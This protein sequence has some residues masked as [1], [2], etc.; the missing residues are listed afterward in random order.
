M[1][2]TYRGS[3]H[4]DGEGTC[5]TT[6]ECLLHPNRNPHLG[7]EDIEQ[8]LR[9]YLNVDK[10][11]WLSKGL[12]ADED[13]NG[14]IDNFCAFVAPGKVVLACCDDEQDPQFAISKAALEILS[15]QVDAK[16]RRIEVIKM[17]CPTPM[18][19]TE[20]EIASYG[21]AGTTRVAGD[22][23]AGSYVNFYIANGE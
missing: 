17:P 9:D 8:Q 22:R 13:T 4:V 18:F 15:S 21:D 12:F 6:E 20:E 23:M 3:I 14:H 1:I 5:L 2:A 19:Y 11:I 7:K 16:G 10:V